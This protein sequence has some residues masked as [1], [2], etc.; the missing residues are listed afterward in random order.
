MGLKYRFGDYP[1]A[2]SGHAGTMD[3][4]AATLQQPGMS[5]PLN[6]NTIQ[7]HECG[8]TIQIGTLPHRHRALCPRCGHKLTEYRTDAGEKILALAI[9]ALVF[10]L[11]AMP[12]DFIAFNAAGQSQVISIPDSLQILFENHYWSLAVLLALVIMVLPAIVILCCIY[13]VICK[14]LDK[15]PGHV[16]KVLKLLYGVLPWSMAEIFL[17]GVLVSLIK[18]VS[19]ADINLGFSFYAFI[20]FV[21]CKTAMLLHM[22]KHQFYAWFDLE[23]VAKPH[24]KAKHSLDIQSTWALLLTA[25]LLYIPANTWPIMQTNM[26]GNS[27]PSTIMGGV[28]LLWKSGSYPIAAIIFIASIVVPTAK[29]GILAWLNLS[30]QTGQLNNPQRKLF[31][32]RV[33]EFVGKWSMVDVF[34][35]AILVSLVQLGTAM[36]IYPGP[37]ALAFAGV[38]IATMLAALS[39][40]PRSIWQPPEHH[41]E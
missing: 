10:L 29:L 16:I 28:I 8:L 32:Y 39:F 17:I 33:T 4:N 12:F 24:S 15:R 7:C 9:S 23:L 22:D 5:N 25:A 19:M 1:I 11:L 38:V 34:V 37:A 13:L 36:S 30:V 18:I 2:I 27:E 14:Q 41:V 3:S 31:W 20:A 35:V 40:N 6:N 26:L 21:F